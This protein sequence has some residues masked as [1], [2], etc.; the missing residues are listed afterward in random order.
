VIKGDPT[1]GALIVAAVKAG[2]REAEMRLE[3]PRVEEIPFSSERKR[4]TTIHQMAGGKRTA[5]TKGAPEVV[6]Q[7]CSHIL[8][9]QGLRELK[10]TERNQILK[11]NEEMAQGALRVLGFAYRDCPDSIACTEEHLEHD[12]VFVGL[13]G[14][15][16]PPEKRRSRR[17][18]YA[19]RW[20]SGPS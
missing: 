18:R 3:N 8:D 4:M 10:E 12:L 17:R 20:G 6:L 5:F 1:E 7:R 19:S 11:V 2:F 9:D 14:M 16:D 15:M 13:A